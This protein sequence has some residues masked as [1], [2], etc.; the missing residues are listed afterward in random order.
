MIPFHL[1]NNYGAGFFGIGDIICSLNALENLAIERD[2]PV[3][4]YVL[5]KEHEYKYKI[6]SSLLNINYINIKYDKDTHDHIEYFSPFPMYQSWV[7]DWI[8]QWG[9]HIRYG[10]NYMVKFNNTIDKIQ[11]K[12]GISFTVNS[13][14]HKNPS[15]SCIK[16]LIKQLLDNKHNI[17]YYGYK[18]DRDDL[19]IFQEFNKYIVFEDYDLS[20]TINSIRECNIFYGADSGMS[21]ISAFAQ[22]PT[23]ILVNKKYGSELPKTF[24]DMTHVKVQWEDIS[25]PINIPVSNGE[26]I[27]KITILDIKSKYITDNDKKINI[28]KEL[29][30]VKTFAQYL[31][32]TLDINIYN[33]LYNINLKLWHIEDSIRNK[34]KK[35]Q[36]DNEFIELAKSVYTINDERS[37][38]KQKINHITKSILID[39]KSYV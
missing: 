32:L 9:N 25:D 7:L 11:N 29:N 37:K 22:N 3:T 33:E 24:F 13:H 26:L 12:T 30:L 2:F 10:E 1:H 27:D 8:K 34:D 28:I 14:K 31:L 20:K 21:W 5:N 17:F 18:G 35:Q 15:N 6:I 38:L 23:V 39:E 36:F 19:W 16:Q 4:L